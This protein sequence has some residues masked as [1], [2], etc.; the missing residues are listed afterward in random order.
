MSSVCSDRLFTP[1]PE[2]RLERLEE[3]ITLLSGKL[4]AFEPEKTQ[5]RRLED[6]NAGFAAKIAT[7]EKRLDLEETRRQR[8]ESDCG[9]LMVSLPDEE[10]KP[11]IKE[12]PADATVIKQV[13][14]LLVCGLTSNSCRN[15]HLSTRFGLR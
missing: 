8:M 9:G 4:E 10:T 5:R 12:E 11:I 15:P 7:L 14:I 1:E 13:R 3:Q 6:Q 2:E